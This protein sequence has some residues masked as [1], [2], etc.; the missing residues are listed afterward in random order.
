MSE[1]RLSFHAFSISAVAAML[2][3]C[4]GQQLT[5]RPPAL[6]Q[7]GFQSR[8]IVEPRSAMPMYKVSGPL[9]YAANADLTLTPLAVYNARADNPK[10]IATI[11]KDIDNSGG[12][13]IDGD[14]ALY[15]ANEPLSGPGWVSEYALGQTKP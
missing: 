3:G 13:C 9:L 4:A 10:P 5:I 7:E 8:E 14:G 1:V 6:L 11:K 15:V 2:T 12:A